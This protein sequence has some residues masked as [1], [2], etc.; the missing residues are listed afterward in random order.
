MNNQQFTDY[1]KE[2]RDAIERTAKEDRPE[3]WEQQK[4]MLDEALRIM[5]YGNGPAR[6]RFRR[7][8]E[9]RLAER[10][11]IEEAVNRVRKMKAIINAEG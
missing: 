10:R 9:R 4:K 2:K 5:T 8:Y 11:K 6:R 1:I 3:G 7:D